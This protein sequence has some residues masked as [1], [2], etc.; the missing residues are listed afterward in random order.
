VLGGW[1]GPNPHRPSLFLVL[2]RAKDTH[3]Y[4]HPF[5][6]TIASQPN[7]SARAVRRG[8]WVVE[9]EKSKT[10]SLR[11]KKRISHTAEIAKLFHTALQS[12]RSQTAGSAAPYPATKIFV[13]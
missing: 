3:T 8:R 5:S 2:D 11:L 1:S 13:K 6:E 9:K 10:S 7:T 12:P 4:A